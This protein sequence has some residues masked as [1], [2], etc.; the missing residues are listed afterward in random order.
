MANAN[1]KGWSYS[2]GERGRN[3]VRAY[4]DVARGT[5]FL[6]F[7]E[8][9][10]GTEEVQ[11]TR[12]S[13]GGNDR[14]AAKCKANR[15]AAQFSDLEKPR[16]EEATLG[17][18]F[19]I[20]TREVTPGKGESKRRHDHRC[21]ALF[22]KC[23]GSTRKV[24]TLNRR[25]WD[26][27]ILERRRGVLRPEGRKGE[28]KKEFGVRDRQIAYDLKFLLSVLNWATLSGDG[29]GAPLLERNPLK[30]LSL[31]REENPR[32]PLVTDEQYRQL[33]RIAP[34]VDPNFEL[35]VVLAHETGHRI[36]AI[37]Q[38]RWSDVD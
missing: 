31:P 25:D 37:R 13:T 3:R 35:A 34:Q 26:R 38:L 24:L 19:D 9:V 30:G 20:Y 22:N 1:N 15:L 27:F 29:Q 33:R 7:Y 32:R 18:L 8:T 28:K 5:I 21:V 36:G 17:K 12:V 14:A 6:E 2:A 16:V 11:R 10:L 4:E 23:F